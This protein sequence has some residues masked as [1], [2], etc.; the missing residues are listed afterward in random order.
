MEDIHTPE[1]DVFD[2][3][4]DI[5]KPSE[6]FSISSYGADYPLEIIPIRIESGDWY[7]PDFQRNFIWSLPQAS[8]F[9]ESLLLGLPVPGI[10]LFKEI[11][12]GKHLIIDGQQRTKSIQLFMTGD[13]FKGRKFRLTNVADRFEG[14]SFAELEEDDQRRLKDSILHATI[15]Q[16]KSP[17]DNIESVYEVFERINTG[18][19]KLSPQEIRSCVNHGEFI[20]LLESLSNLDEWR[21]IFRSTSVRLKDHELILR[22]FAFLEQLDNYSSPMKKFLDDNMARFR[23]PSEKQGQEMANI[24]G[25]TFRFVIEQIGEKAFRPEGVFNAAV[26][27]SVAVETAKLLQS[28]GDIEDYQR[29]YEALMADQDFL[30]LS[31]RST[32]DAERVKSRFS[33]ARE[34]LS[35]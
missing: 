17:E 32:A 20:D 11:D 24:F 12:T 2:P 26:F 21:R 13:D 34:Y 29:R 3:T 14:R 30:E 33:K 7:T 18:G 4:D 5:D 25:N 31:S 35:N 23:N 10:F 19:S 16:Q 6:V 1:D 8:R 9:I 28:Q 15:F 27:D 22:F